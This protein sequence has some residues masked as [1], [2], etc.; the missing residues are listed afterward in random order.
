MRTPA[1]RGRLGLSF[2]TEV[3]EELLDPVLGGAGAPARVEP[4]EPVAQS[5]LGAVE[6]DAHSLP[7]RTRLAVQDRDMA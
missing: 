7:A 5:F 2:V 4:R 6:S 1:A 3:Q